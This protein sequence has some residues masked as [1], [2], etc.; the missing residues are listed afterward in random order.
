MARCGNE[1]GNSTKP[2][3][4]E[5]HENRLITMALLMWLVGAEMARSNLTTWR[6][7]SGAIEASRRGI[8]DSW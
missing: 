6:S 7:I 4:E 2:Q 8:Y 3:I 5:Q 1:C